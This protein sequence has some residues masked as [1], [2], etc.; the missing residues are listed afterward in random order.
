MKK[1]GYKTIAFPALGTGKLGYSYI[2][3][4][5]AMKETLIEFGKQNPDTFV[6][7]VYIILHEKEKQCI[8][9]PLIFVF[10]L[11]GIL[12]THF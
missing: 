3:V 4:A 10:N 7:T 6:E 1:E 11:K 9:V 5:K 12:N 2:S 8:Q